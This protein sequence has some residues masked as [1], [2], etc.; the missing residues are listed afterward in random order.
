MT[1]IMAIAVAGGFGALARYGLAGAVQ[2]AFGPAFPWGT[3]VVN[4]AGCFA[5]GLV[6]A[7]VQERDLLSPEMRTIVLVGFLGAFTTFSTFVFESGQL[8]S[9][10]E[11]L[12][13]LCN[14]ALQVLG[15]L[16]L[17]FAGQVLGRLI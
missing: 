1:K 10:R 17:F 12:L 8:F 13:G 6:W 2:R 3:A 11:M 16:A 4:I 7:A 15:G 5:F 9:D 14:L